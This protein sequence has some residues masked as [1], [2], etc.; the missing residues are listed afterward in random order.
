MGQ[1]P[2]EIL[3]RSLGP[4]NGNPSQPSYPRSILPTA[5]ALT[6]FEIEA[7]NFSL[8][9]ERSRLRSAPLFSG[10]L[11]RCKQ[12]ISACLTTWSFGLRFHGVYRAT[13][14]LASVLCPGE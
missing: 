12:G 10:F 14:N 7:D 11:F 13:C 5:F 1:R 9:A 4:A 6:R 8:L 2:H 3:F